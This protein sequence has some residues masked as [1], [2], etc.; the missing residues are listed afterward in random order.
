MNNI[1]EH[2]K[3]ELSVPECREILQKLIKDHGRQNIA[4]LFEE[5]NEEENEA[6]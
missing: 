3:R 6:D 4:D 5:K 1:E 2:R